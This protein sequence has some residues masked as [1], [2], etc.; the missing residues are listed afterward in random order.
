VQ[1]LPPTETPE[2][3]QPL[4]TP[5]AVISAPNEGKAGQAITFDGSG[6]TASAEITAYLWEFGDGTV[7]D[8]ATLEHT[9][10]NPG[11]YTVTLTVTDANN[12]VGSATLEVTIE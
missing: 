8:G 9:F 1:P 2:A 5:Q 3:V 7:K 4:P 6:S 10:V 12:Q 11:T